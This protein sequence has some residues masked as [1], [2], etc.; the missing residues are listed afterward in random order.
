MAAEK[1]ES[2]G[3]ALNE[4][5]PEDWLGDAADAQAG[6]SSHAAGLVYGRELLEQFGSTLDRRMKFRASSIEWHRFLGF[7]SSQTVDEEVRGKRAAP[8]E[9]EADGGAVKRRRLLSRVDP[10][11]AFKEM[12][13]DANGQLYEAQEAGIRAVLRG[14]NVVLAVMKTGGGKSLIFQLPAWLAASGTTIIV[15][16]FVALRADLKRRSVELGISC[17]EWDSRRPPDEAKMVLVT[18]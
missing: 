11:A 7:D 12:S 16:P 14:D 3:G 8:W 13:N 1:E 15:V 10:Q 17:L 6:H 9:E 18:P 2:E 5:D 4:E